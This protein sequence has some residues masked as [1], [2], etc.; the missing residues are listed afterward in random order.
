MYATF[1]VGRF[2]TTALQILCVCNHLHLT[3]RLFYYR[4]PESVMVVILPD[5][6]VKD[7]SLRIQHTL[8]EAFCR[9]NEVK[10]LKVKCV[11]LICVKC[12]ILLY[13]YSFSID[14]VIY[15]DNCFL[16]S[17]FLICFVVLSFGHFAKH[18][19]YR[20]ISYLTLY[21]LVSKTI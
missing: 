21:C 3:L 20:L 16:M 11:H 7:A 8:I 15:L 6:K 18:R 13:M 14:T 10:V 9:E 5:S 2:S 1:W 12:Y 17:V 4:D 19:G